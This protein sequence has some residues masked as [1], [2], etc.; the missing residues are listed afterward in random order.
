MTDKTEDQMLIEEE[1]RDNIVDA[2][3]NNPLENIMDDDSIL[4]EIDRE[5]NDIT[6]SEQN[7]ISKGKNMKQ[8]LNEF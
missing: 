8:T 1:S 2:A 6:S 7:R 3:I 4:K 5:I